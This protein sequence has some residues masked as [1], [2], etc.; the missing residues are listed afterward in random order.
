MLRDLIT[1]FDQAGDEQLFA[2]G[3]TQNDPRASCRRDDTISVPFLLVTHGRIFPRLGSGLLGGCGSGAANGKIGIADSSSSGGAGS[4]VAAQTAKAT[5]ASD[6]AE[7]KD[8]AVVAVDGEFL[9]VAIGDGARGVDEPSAHNRANDIHFLR[10]A[11][12]DAVRQADGKRK[13][14]S[15]RSGNEHAAFR[16]KRLKVR[17]TFPA[18]AGPHVVGGI[19]LADEV[20]RYRRVFP[21]HPIPPALFPP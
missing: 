5:A 13:A 7:R 16:N 17:D 9:V 15:V 18:E 3:V 14:R 1:T 2:V 12:A 10:S 4:A 21:V 6:A 19:I 8:G 20:R 11:D